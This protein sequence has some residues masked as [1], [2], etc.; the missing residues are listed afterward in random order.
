MDAK[1]DQEWWATKHPGV[2]INLMAFV[3]GGRR[4]TGES[5]SAYAV[6]AVRRD[7]MRLIGSG[8]CYA[9]DGDSFVAECRAMG[10][11]TAILTK[12][13]EAWSVPPPPR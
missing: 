11:A 4:N 9:F 5:A 7:Q 6:F 3:D 13:L 12:T 10:M 1:A 8:A 2:D